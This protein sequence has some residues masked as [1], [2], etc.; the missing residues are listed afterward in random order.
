M[1][2]LRQTQEMLKK[3][4]P[5]VEVLSLRI[6]VR[7]KPQVKDGIAELVGKFGR[8]DIA[9]N[10]AGTGGT[11]KLTHETPDEEIERIVDTNLHGVYRCQ[12]EELAVMVKQE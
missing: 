8:L 12:K 1:P 7:Q 6:D 11:A 5:S 10:N 9:V 2:N 4:F 3:R